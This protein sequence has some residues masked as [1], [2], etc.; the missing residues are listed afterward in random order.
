MREALVSFWSACKQFFA[1]PHVKGRLF[2]GAVVSLFVCVGY[3][4]FLYFLPEPRVWVGL[5]TTTEY[6]AFRV[7]QPDLV[8]FGVGGMSASSLDQGRRCVDGVVA[9][10]AG[11]WVEYRRGGP[12]E[13]S[14]QIHPPAN[15]ESSATIPGDKGTALPLTGGVQLVLDK[16]CRGDPPTRL[17]ILGPAVFGHQPEPTKANGLQPGILLKGVV[18]VYALAQE[19]LL[20]MKFPSSV[21]LLSSF[22]LP[23]GSVICADTAREMA[24][25]SQSADCHGLGEQS[26][27][28]DRGLRNW[29]GVVTPSV[30]NNGF[31]I[32]ATATAAGLILESSLTF[33]RDAPV[34]RIDLGAHDQFLKDPNI[35]WVQF[36]VGA[37]LLIWQAVLSVVGFFLEGRPKQD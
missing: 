17:P 9:P 3:L 11:A 4:L 23:P 29:V 30:F 34:K 15:G 36:R 26:R 19:H 8:A 25:E 10:K 2:L 35:L 24:P 27:D 31:D 14:I 33:G 16:T 5:K 1:H 28:D 13:L 20:L 32:A 7:T 12:K 22:E 18:D 37:L 21:Y 6:A